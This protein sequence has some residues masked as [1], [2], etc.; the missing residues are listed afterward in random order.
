MSP[1]DG[2]DYHKRRKQDYVRHSPRSG[3]ARLASHPVLHFKITFCSAAPLGL[4]GVGHGVVRDWGQSQQCL[5]T[6]E[7]CQQDVAKSKD[8]LGDFSKR[9]VI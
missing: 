4:C 2:S 9:L 3:A 8:D 7:E 6:W 5:Q 1:K